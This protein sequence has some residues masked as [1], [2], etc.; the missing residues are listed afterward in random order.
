MQ[1]NSAIIKA[2]KAGVDMAEIIAPENYPHFTPFIE[3]IEQVG[4][5][6]GGSTQRG[7]QRG[8]AQLG[9]QRLL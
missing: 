6:A 1:V 3:D 7:R 5:P 8:S 4:A 2:T 9:R